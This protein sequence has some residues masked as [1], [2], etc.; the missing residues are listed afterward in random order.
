MKS[1]NNNLPTVMS[2]E[3]TSTVATEVRKVLAEDP[4]AEW[5]RDYLVY[6]EMARELYTRMFKIPYK[7]P[8][9]LAKELFE[10]MY[11]EFLQA[12]GERPDLSNNS[13]N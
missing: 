12:T 6:E 10:E 8:L 2:A 13:N 5:K 1:N 4:I 7:D 9:D 3:E 11:A